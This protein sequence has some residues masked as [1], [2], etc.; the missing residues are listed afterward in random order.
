[1][2]TGFR[3]DAR[4]GSHSRGQTRCHDHVHRETNQLCRE[5]G[6]Q[7]EVTLG[8]PR[9]DDDILTIHVAEIAQAIGDGL[10]RGAAGM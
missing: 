3:R 4:S 8:T 2:P 10:P 6:Q 7:I 1:M 9:L 5:V